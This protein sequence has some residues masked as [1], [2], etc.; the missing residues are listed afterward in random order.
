MGFK[1][2]MYSNTLPIVKNESDRTQFWRSKINNFSPS[3]TKALEDIKTMPDT[4]GICGL[5]CYHV[6]GHLT[7]PNKWKSIHFKPIEDKKRF[8]EWQS[9]KFK[10][11]NTTADSP[12]I[13]FLKKHSKI[14]TISP[15]SVRSINK[16]K[17]LYKQ[18]GVN[19]QIYVAVVPHYPKHNGSF[20]HWL[21]LLDLT[22]NDTAII[23]GD[24][25]PFG[26]TDTFVQEV[27]LNLFCKMIVDTLSVGPTTNNSPALLSE[28]A[29]LSAGNSQK[30]SSNVYIAT[31]N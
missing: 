15:H 4:F 30:F 17:N 7:I 5:F 22:S 12:A 14:F 27:K 11:P 16:L 26:L 29:K 23:A 3:F 13:S 18:K 21:T 6:M 19:Q 10:N 9:Y 2:F 31:F 24:L 25:S 8:D 20:T 1:Q 28:L